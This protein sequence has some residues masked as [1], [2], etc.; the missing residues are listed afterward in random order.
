[1]AWKGAAGGQTSLLSKAF[2]RVEMTI[3]SRC[4]GGNGGVLRCPLP[5]AKNLNGRT[6][7]RPT[8]TKT[9]THTIV[10]GHTIKLTGRHAMLL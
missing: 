5:D 1:M 3:L 7:K 2:C 10:A 4:R 9:S 6:E 8:A